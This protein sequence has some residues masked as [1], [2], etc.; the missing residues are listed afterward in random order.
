MISEE[1]RQKFTDELGII[2][3]SGKV[4]KILEAKEIY[5][6][7]GTIAT[8]STI[9][10]VFGGHQED[11][12]IELAIYEVYEKELDKKNKLEK[13]RNKHSKKPEAQP[14]SSNG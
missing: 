10:N 3:Y 12:D 7:R 8:S 9:R 11:E 1:F 4:Q 14:Q 2:R 13:L 6:N 5:T